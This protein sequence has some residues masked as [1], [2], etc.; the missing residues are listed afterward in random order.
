MR[1]VSHLC[2]RCLLLD[3]G[4]VVRDGTVSE[5]IRGYYEALRKVEVGAATAVDDARFRRGSGA[6]RFTRIDVC[7]AAGEPRNEFDMGETIRFHLEYEVFRPV[8]TLQVMV[9]LKGP[10]SGDTVT[11]ARFQAAAGKIAPGWKGSLVVEFPNPN[12]RPAEYP[13]YFWLGDDGDL[14]YDTV[15]GLAGPLLIR[16]EK[17]FRELG[18]DPS[19]PS[20]FFSIQATARVGAGACAGTRARGNHAAVLTPMGRAS[21]Y[22]AARGRRHPSL[23]PE[24]SPVPADG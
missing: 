5:V 3:G 23:R 10:G 2:Q 6:A 22:V 13:L 24:L 15:D 12:L 7:D 18:F 1:A 19:R 8:D 11:S 17:S 21:K 20:G 16:T 14:S 9:L 4:K